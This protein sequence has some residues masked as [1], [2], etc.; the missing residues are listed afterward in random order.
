MLW[1][2]V[3]RVS[4]G[5][6]YYDLTMW[7]INTS[8]LMLE[9]VQNPE[10][11][12]YAILSH[13]WGEEE[14]SFQELASPEQVWG[15]KGFEKI[16]A[17]CELARR[18]DP[19]LPFAW[20]DTC[21]IDKTSSAELAESLN[22]MFAWYKK[23][24]V[25]FVLLSDLPAHASEIPDPKLPSCRW[26]TRGW[27]L[28]E[29]IAPRHMEFYD[30]DWNYHGTKIDR[31]DEIANITGVAPMVLKDSSL[32]CT[33]P[34]GVRMSWAAE[35]QTSREE[36]MAYC[37]LGIFDVNMAMIYGEGQK[38]FIRLQKQIMEDSN[39]M[40]LF[41]W[42]SHDSSQKYRGILARSTSEF[43]ACHH[44]ERSGG[45]L[46]L[47]KDYTLTNNGLR[48]HTHLAKVEPHGPGND[49]DH[50]LSLNCKIR[51]KTLRRIAIHLA[52]TPDGFV[53]RFPDKLCY[54]H[55]AAAWAGKQSTAYI[56]KDVTAEESRQLSAQLDRTI[57]VT[58]NLPMGFLG[59][60]KAHPSAVWDEHNL[61]FMLGSDDSIRGSLILD[62]DDSYTGKRMT[63]AI[64]CLLLVTHEERHPYVKW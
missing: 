28:Q 41:A 58:L 22:S 11:Q 6:I 63:V 15:K 60:L 24:T 38:A 49:Y 8:T 47:N 33:F 51:G 36:D 52:K 34:V 3:H 13:T 46:N 43:K 45:S 54:R 57:K 50:V 29:L 44:L 26:F 7:L 48:I 39:D 17:T 5:T 56:R 19:P 64:F 21:C 32:L 1:I 20:V 27:T 10:S 37:L 42:V 53:R 23:A 2:I 62:L 31:L 35:R 59:S 9:L 61:T 40:T 4:S 55:N 16:R 30:S 18:Q 14:V 25:C 12:P